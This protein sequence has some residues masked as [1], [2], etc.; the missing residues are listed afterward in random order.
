MIKEGIEYRIAQDPGLGSIRY[1]VHP[2]TGQIVQEIAF[3]KWKKDIMYLH[4][5]QGN[6]AARKL[7][8]NLG[9]K[10]I[11]NN[12]ENNLDLDKGEQALLYSYRLKS[13]FSTVIQPPLPPE[14]PPAIPPAKTM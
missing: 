2:H 5:L 6:L 8:N 11:T 9:Y 3:I 4:V 14:I 7:Y 1:I 12:F 13:L 10:Q